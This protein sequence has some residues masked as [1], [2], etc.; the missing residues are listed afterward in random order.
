MT[1]PTRVAH[2]CQ[3][4]EGQDLIEY[5][6]LATFISLMFVAVGALLGGAVNNWYQG[7]SGTVNAAAGS[8]RAP[9]GN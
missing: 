3:D 8:A 1:I 7:I 9:G 6:L 4:D 2:L 5:V